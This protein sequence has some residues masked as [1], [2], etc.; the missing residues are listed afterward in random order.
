MPA[1]AITMILH[2]HGSDI[3]DACDDCIDVDLDN[4]C[5]DVDNCIGL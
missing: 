5:A 2:G 4:V 3:G 1:V